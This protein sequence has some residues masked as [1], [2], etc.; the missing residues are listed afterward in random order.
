[1]IFGS[2]VIFSLLV[3]ACSSGTTADVP[4]DT[5]PTSSAPGPNDSRRAATDVPGTGPSTGA[6]GTT[7]RSST[8]DS[9]APGTTVDPMA[10]T[11]LRAA[12]LQEQDIA[13]PRVVANGTGKFRSPQP[14]E[15]RFLSGDACDEVKANHPDVLAQ[16]TT[17][18]SI[19]IGFSVGDPDLDTYVFITESIDRFASEEL[20]R[21]YVEVLADP[22]YGACRSGGYNALEFT[23]EPADLGDGAAFVKGTQYDI[24]DGTKTEDVVFWIIRHGRHVIFLTASG[25]PVADDLKDVAT[26]ALERASTLD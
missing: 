23:A 9:R 17:G 8:G 1:M 20:A 19:G 18:A 26:K 6:P 11:E 15:E 24:D 21:A 25:G 12:L 22:A 3:T 10:E 2:S 13:G 5:G 7:G 4:S 14:I 16:A